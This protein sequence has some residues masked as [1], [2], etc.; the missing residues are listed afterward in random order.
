MPQSRMFAQA[1]TDTACT[2]EYAASQT[3]CQQDLEDDDSQ[4]CSQPLFHTQQSSSKSENQQLTPQSP[5]TAP[6]TTEVTQSVDSPRQFTPRGFGR[7]TPPA[8]PF[9][10]VPSPSPSTRGRGA[11]RGRDQNPGRRQ[12]ISRNDSPR[13]TR[14]QS[15]SQV[16][17]SQPKITD[18][19]LKLNTSKNVIHESV[20]NVQSDANK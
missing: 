14:S 2:P 15:Q 1:V 17:P 11:G 8:T 3:S 9:Q 16:H 4:C 18:K 7:G 12:D 5:M 6:M 13:I 20:V 10:D 19:W